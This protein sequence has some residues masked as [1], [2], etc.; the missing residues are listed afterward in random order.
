MIF[1]DNAGVQHRIVCGSLRKVNGTWTVVNDSINEPSDLS[2]GTVTS[3]SIQVLFPASP[4]M[5]KFIVGVDA[6][7]AGAHTVSF[8]GN[9]GISSASIRGR[10]D[11]GPFN[12]LTWSE[13]G[14]IRIDGLFRV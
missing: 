11:G 14:A 13:S 3:T 2:I 8:G 5:E 6:T 10:V 4:Q 7:F 1:T 12:P 9:V